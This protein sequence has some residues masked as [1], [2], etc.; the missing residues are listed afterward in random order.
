MDNLDIPAV[1]AIACAL[2]S[3]P[4]SP[5]YTYCNYEYDPVLHSF[6]LP[7][8]NHYIARVLACV[9][10]QGYLAHKKQRPSRTLQ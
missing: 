2:A 4:P 3:V 9:P 10:P 1:L 6:L 7:E 5:P 8:S